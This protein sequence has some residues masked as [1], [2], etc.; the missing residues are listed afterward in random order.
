MKINGQKLKKIRESKG[1]SLRDLADMTGISVSTL[2]KWEAAPSANP[3]PSKLQIATA[4]L[5]IKIDDIY[6][7]DETQIM[8]KR[9]EI[10][11][12]QPIIHLDTPRDFLKC[13]RNELRPDNVET[14]YGLLGLIQFK[15]DKESKGDPDSM[16]ISY[17]QKNGCYEGESYTAKLFK[18]IYGQTEDRS[19]TI[20]NCW[21]FFRMFKEAR[22]IK[23]SKMWLDQNRNP[24]F[25][26]VGSDSV[27]GNL[28]IL[29]SGYEDIFGLLNELADLHHCLANMMPAPIGYNGHDEKDGKGNCKKDNDMPDIYYK[30]AK[31]DFPDHYKWI[32]DNMENYCLQFFEE[33][34]SPWKNGCANNPLNLSDANAVWE[35]KNAIID[36]IN[37]IYNR[38][39]KLYK[40]TIRNGEK[41]KFERN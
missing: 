36:A 18:E 15:L 1:Y 13:I 40:L 19:D 8:K 33:Y 30:R 29:F 4:K 6:L 10:S 16:Y 9:N 21:S 14:K 27:Q 22:T 24:I 34:T 38:S 23:F 35:Y 7:D 28:K 17:N 5:G 31:D 12:E 3:F 11:N 41:H 25:E 26:N 39:I 20:F 32:Q 2:V 37:C